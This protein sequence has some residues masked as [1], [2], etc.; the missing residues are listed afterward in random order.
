M[1][2]SET[3]LRTQVLTR[4]VSRVR[5]ARALRFT[6][7]AV[8]AL[9]WLSGALWLMAHFLL[10]L[11][12]EFGTLPNPAEPYL[13]RLH[14][15][16]AVGGVFLLGWIMAE[17]VPAGWAR[18]LNR[19]SGLWL[20]GFALVLVASGYALYYST[21]GLHEGAAA[22]HE[23]LGIAALIAALAHWLKIRGSR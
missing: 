9:L 18:A 3:Q 20:S 13:M 17:H 22:V 15:V 12:N 19:P 8:G 7:Y 14:G 2:H 23:V 21:G 11:H 6:I 10:P 5:M 1:A 4:S 16:L